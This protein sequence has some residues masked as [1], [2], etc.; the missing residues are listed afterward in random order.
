MTRD[1]EPTMVGVK[2]ID[3]SE[4]V[5]GKYRA[6]TMASDGLWYAD[7]DFTGPG[8]TG[9]PKRGALPALHQ[10]TK[11]KT[12]RAKKLHERANRTTNPHYYGMLAI[13]GITVIVIVLLFS[14]LR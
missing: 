13:A 1:E 8:A 9:N 12:D 11:E 2:G 4:Q 5:Y 10:D 14:G 7:S 3:I 6:C